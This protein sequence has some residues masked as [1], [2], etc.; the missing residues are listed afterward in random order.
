MARSGEI[1]SDHLPTN[2]APKD[3]G[4]D[5]PS[6]AG[7][8]RAWATEQLNQ[9]TLSHELYAEFLKSVEPALFAAVL[10]R[11]AHNR[12]AAANVLGL[13][14]ATLRKKLNGE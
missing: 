8:V 1:L 3:S 10:E 2:I 9:P 4:P 12:A 11:T 13:H 5:V 7:I 6:L 14:R